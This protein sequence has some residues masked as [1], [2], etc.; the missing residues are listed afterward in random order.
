MSGKLLFIKNKEGSFVVFAL[1]AF[2]AVL[3]LLIVLINASVNLAI[4]SSADSI[5]SVWCK[6]QLGKYDL[7][8]KNRYGILAFYG[9]GH[10]VTEEIEKYAEYSFSDKNYIKVDEIKVGLTKYNLKNTECMKTSIVEA[11]KAGADPPYEEK[12]DVMQS[13]NRTI[14]AD[15]II[16]GL[17]SYGLTE[18]LYLD[19]LI[20]QIKIG[21]G[22]DNLIKQ[23]IID[24]YIFK[25]FKDYTNDRDLPETY[26][27][28]EIEYI[29]SG[30]L[31]DEQ[32]KKNVGVKL[33]VMRN[34][35][36]LY[37]L[38]A[39]PEKRQGALALAEIL[40]PG[41]A[42]V[43]TQAVILET[44]AYQ[45]AENDINILYE[46]GT[47]PLLKTDEN[48]ALTLENV[49]NEDGSEK[50]HKDK[51][52]VY[53]Q[54]SE[55]EKYETYLGIL[56][57]GMTNETKLLRIMDL[58]QINGKYTYN[59]GFLISDFCNGIQFQMKINGKIHEFEDKY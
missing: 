14:S 24:K 7:Y 23:Q 59:A 9:N 6:S 30:K 57:C 18:N 58:I 2:S 55:G 27:N 20:K 40:S 49:F 12:E 42:A 31:S 53:P 1:M 29:I 32:S 35:L 36:N 15:W 4:G 47:V 45:E 16:K 33:K 8:L 44:W 10:S 11:V 22:V 39:C 34:L 48:W 54:K 51:H 41:P 46:G 19:G 17:P 3:I 28:N 38:Y 37:Y 13:Q 56:L 26:F 25:F 50:E 5:A 43:L 52:I 21:I